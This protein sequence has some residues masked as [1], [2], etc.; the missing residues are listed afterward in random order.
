MI[1]SSIALDVLALKS[2]SVGAGDSVEGT[3]AI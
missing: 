3:V 2:R 1:S